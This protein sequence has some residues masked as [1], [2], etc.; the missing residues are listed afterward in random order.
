[1][2][3]TSRT[4]TKV[5]LSDLTVQCGMAVTQRIK[6]TLG[7][8]G[9]SPHRVPIDE[10]VWHL[11]V[12]SSHPGGAV[13]PKGLAVRQL[14][15]YVSWVQNVARQFGPYP[16]YAYEECEWT[17]SSTR[18]PRK[19]YLWCTSYRACGRCWVATYSLDKC[20]KHI[21]MKPSSRWL[22]SESR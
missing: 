19:I 6:V 16:A 20:W 10:E 17:F 18:G 22:F 5:G 12:G 13:P 11:D 21:S 15:R 1:M 8:T 4:E 2:R 7:I 14:K 3:Q 9:W